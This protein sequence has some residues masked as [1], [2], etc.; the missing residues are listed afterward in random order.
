MKLNWF[1]RVGFLVY[2]ATLWAWLMLIV[3]CGYL[4]YVFIEIDS[5]SHS[6]SD[7]LM[8]WAFNAILI[9]GALYIFAMMTT[10]KKSSGSV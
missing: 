8:N 2:P 9:G 3:A 6:V 7:T 4:V 10:E 1:K 5:R